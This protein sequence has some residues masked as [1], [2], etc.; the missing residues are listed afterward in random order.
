MK[1]DFSYAVERVHVSA[2][3]SID[4]II[5]APDLWYSL[6]TKFK[7]RARNSVGQRSSGQADMTTGIV[8]YKWFVCT[9]INVALQEFVGDICRQRASTRAEERVVCGKT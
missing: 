9:H 4:N 5:V 7:G 2:L 3:S 6:A 8:V 1:P